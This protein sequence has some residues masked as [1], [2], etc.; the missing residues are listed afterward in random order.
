MTL[1]MAFSSRSDHASFEAATMKIPLEIMSGPA[2]AFDQMAMQA[3][4]KQLDSKAPVCLLLLFTEL[5]QL[6]VHASKV[7]L[8]TM[9]IRI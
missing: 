4:L 7:F 3:G 9:R 1:S 6:Y 2:R 5:G 8:R